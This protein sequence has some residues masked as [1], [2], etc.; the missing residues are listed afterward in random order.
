MN[1]K[2]LE[3]KCV[4]LS[5]WKNNKDKADWIEKQLYPRN[6]ANEVRDELQMR[7]DD[8]RTRMED[9]MEEINSLDNK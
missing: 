9:I 7:M 1:F 8:V 5:E 4:L 6:L 3:N 2:V